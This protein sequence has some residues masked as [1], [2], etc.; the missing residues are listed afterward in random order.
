MWHFFDSPCS[1]KFLWSPLWRKRSLNFLWSPLWKRNALIILKHPVNYILVLIPFCAV[2]KPSK[3]IQTRETTKILCKLA[4]SEFQMNFNFSGTYGDKV[5]GYCF[6]PPGC[7][8]TECLLPLTKKCI[9]SFVVGDD[10]VPRA[11]YHVCVCIFSFDFDF[12]QFLVICTLCRVLW[13]LLPFTKKVC[14]SM[15]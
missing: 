7:I 12:F 3:F 5:R 10:F 11:S 13:N 15:K 6:S 9:M 4:S 1:Q 2:L 8:V 14:W